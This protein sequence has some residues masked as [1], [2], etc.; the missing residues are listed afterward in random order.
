MTRRAVLIS[1]VVSPYIARTPLPACARCAECVARCSFYAVA[2]V[3]SDF[4]LVAHSAKASPFLNLLEGLQQQWS[5]GSEDY[6]I[7]LGNEEISVVV[8]PHA[9]G[10]TA[11][12]FL[13]RQQYETYGEFAIE[14][15]QRAI[16]PDINHLGP[17]IQWAYIPKERGG[18][19][20]FTVIPR[21]KTTCV[22]LGDVEGRG[23]VPSFLSL[24]FLGLLETALRLSPTVED[25]L[26]TA[27]R[28]LSAHN[29]SKIVPCV[30]LEISSTSSA[31][32]YFAGGPPPI[33]IPSDGVGR[34]I[35]IYEESTPLGML[36]AVVSKTEIPK[37]KVVLY[38]D[39]VY[40][41]I[42]RKI[43]T[44]E[45]MYERWR[46]FV[47][48]CSKS[49]DLAPRVLL[50]RFRESFGEENE[51]ELCDD[52]TVLVVDLEQWQCES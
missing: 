45:T 29:V 19:D 25:A 41:V 12:Y 3:D 30:V 23:L 49:E 39:G 24:Y 52:A 47:M 9:S 18:G 10:Y 38:T 5:G 28:I 8:R 2:L 51:I 22:L 11:I 21:G 17:W 15:T 16:L 37:G 46:D 13:T 1:R 4:C 34:A 42:R 32:L 7:Q 31:T 36:N 43:N 48:S 35:E 6:V 27:N 33:I 14:A 20:F 40:E 50:V 44:K 26:Y